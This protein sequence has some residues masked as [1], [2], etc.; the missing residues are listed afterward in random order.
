MRVSPR[1]GWQLRDAA[2]WWSVN[3]TAAPTLFSDELEAAYTL[4]A[5]MPY[6]GEGVPHPQIAGL[7]RILLGR[8]QYYLYYSPS[9]EERT[10]DI[11]SLWHSSRG[12]P[13]RI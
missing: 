11:L 8:T 9:E 4:I 12:E 2:R 13:P 3:R 1:A 6:A 5:D 10:I 7:R